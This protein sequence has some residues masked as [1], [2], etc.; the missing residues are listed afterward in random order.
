MRE[1]KFRGR[2]IKSN[3]W[4]CGDL[5]HGVGGKSGKLYILPNK[6][7]LASVKHCDPLDGVQVIPDSVGQ[8]TGLKDKKGIDIYKGDVLKCDWC[9]RKM[10]SRGYVNKKL[11]NLIEGYAEVELGYGEFKFNFIKT[12]PEHKDIYE[13][14]EQQYA[15][16]G[17]T[18]NNYSIKQDHVT[19][20]G[21]IYEFVWAKK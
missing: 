13:K 3:D 20:I 18:I 16:V 2:C 19:V 12:I 17:Y 5:I 15:Y 9:F 11:P 6:I 8:F 14:H 7:N 21:N 4:V 10:P 1:I